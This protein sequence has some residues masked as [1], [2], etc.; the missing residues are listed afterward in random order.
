ME[1][2][3]NQ[4]DIY[5]SFLF[6]RLKN[7][8]RLLVSNEKIAAKQEFENMIGNCQEKIFLRTYFLT[9]LKSG[10]DI[11]FWR[12]SE[13]LQFLQ[14]ICSRSFSSGI[15]K[16]FEQTSSYIGMYKVPQGTQDPYAYMQANFGIY[17]Y[18]LLHPLIKSQTWYEMTHQER[19]ALI[20][21][22]AR[23][24]APYADIKENFFYSYGIDDQDMVVTR[25]AKS[26]ETLIEATKE[27]KKQRIK[28]YTV[29]DRPVYLAIGR[30]LRD[31]LDGLS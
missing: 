22:R 8:F 16:Y 25:E 20:S 27:L 5:S 18:L 2:K 24:L 12:M 15:G 17:K 29:S 1:Q 14:E 23:A 4:T 7:E 21:E 3:I 19:E 31:I 28:N 10:C 11:L 9:G 26:L 6:L 13:D 30:D